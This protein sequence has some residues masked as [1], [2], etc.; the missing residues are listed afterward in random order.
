MGL[1]VRSIGGDSGIERVSPAGSCASLVNN[2]VEE[3]AGINLD[4]R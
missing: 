1:D 4:N 3:I 2:T